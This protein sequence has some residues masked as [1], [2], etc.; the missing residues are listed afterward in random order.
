M[1]EVG[2]QLMEAAAL[3]ALKQQL[4]P[5]TAGFALHWGA[6]GP[7]KAHAVEAGLLGN[8]PRAVQEAMRFDTGFS[9][10]SHERD[11]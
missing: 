7:E 5:I 9:G 1:A 2:Q 8:R 4:S 10:R 3:P 6:D 11:S